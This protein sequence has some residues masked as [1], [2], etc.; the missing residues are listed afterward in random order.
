MNEFD[1]RMKERAR[2]EDCPIPE[3]FDRRM[4][5]ALEQL[6][7]AAPR[8]GGRFYRIV[9]AAAVLCVLATAAGAVGAAL[10]QTQV[11]FFQDEEELLAA[12]EEDK[13][14]G[15]NG[16]YIPYGSQDFDPDSL[17][18]ENEKMW[19]DYAGGTITEERQGT[20]ADGWT[21][22]RAWAFTSGEVP[23]QAELY[24]AER[25][26]GLDGL[27]DG[28]SLDVSWLEEHY[29][30][31]PGTCVYHTETDL[32][33]GK[34]TYESFIGG[35]EG[36]DGTSFNVEC[37]W[38]YQYEME[39]NRYEVADGVHYVTADG[40]TVA[41]TMWTTAGGQ[42]R[43]D[44]SVYSGHMAWY[45]QGAGLELEEIQTLADHMGLAALCEYA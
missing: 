13:T 43:F 30:T 32:E 9:A 38:F 5:A 22:M 35:F 37:S 8:R 1:M 31:R 20:E 40:V 24:R 11:H 12:M 4:D 2:R 14:G 26:S 28:P 6:P 23:Y 44:A 17:A 33:T 34:L 27:R 3:G 16:Y 25:L 41:I 7:Q 19:N 21:D 10:R 39:E 36:E 42:Q 18:K 45:M 15:L 29:D